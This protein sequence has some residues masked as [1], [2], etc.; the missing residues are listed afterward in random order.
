MIVLFLSD[1]DLQVQKGT[2]KYNVCIRII[3]LML[4]LSISPKA[5]TVK[6]NYKTQY[7]SSQKISIESPIPVFHA[8]RECVS[9][10][11]RREV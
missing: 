8:Y 1:L 7:F 10:T 9:V 2:F 5:P 3:R 4:S 6:L 11:D